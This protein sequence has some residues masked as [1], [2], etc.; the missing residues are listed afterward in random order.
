MSSGGRPT[1]GTRSLDFMKSRTS[2]EETSM[3]GR[4]AVGGTGPGG[5]IALTRTLYRESST[6]RAFVSIFTPPF[7]AL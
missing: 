3:P 5:A 7:D 2:P 6:A 1:R 4:K